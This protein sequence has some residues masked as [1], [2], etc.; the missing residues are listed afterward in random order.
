[1]IKS[2]GFGN[3]LCTLITQTLEIF[4]ILYVKR[5]A[6]YGTGYIKTY[7]STHV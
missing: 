4:V 6:S 5:S 7:N 3:E 2:A 1:M